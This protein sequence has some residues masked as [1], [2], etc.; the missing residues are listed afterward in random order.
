MQ[1]LSHTEADRLAAMVGAGEPLSAPTRAALAQ[2][3]SVCAACASRE[4]RLAGLVEALQA[5]PEGASQVGDRELIAKAMIQAGTGRPL[6]Q[7]SRPGRTAAILAVAASVAL[8]VVNGLTEYGSRT[9]RAEH[10]PPAN[11]PPSSAEAE[12]DK[13]DVLAAAPAT[14]S[15][16]TPPPAAEP[17]SRL[18][19]PGVRLSWS[20]EPA[21]Q[22][23]A[24]DGRV[25]RLSLQAGV[26][27][28]V[29]D[30]KAH[31]RV[32][33]DT[34]SA[35]VRV[36]GTIFQVAVGD[37]DTSVAVYRGQV[38]VET[39]A[40]GLQ[41]QAG[42]AATS[43]DGVLVRGRAQPEALSTL[44]TLAGGDSPPARAATVAAQRS[45]PT[46]AAEAKRARRSDRGV[47]DLRKL[48]SAGDTRA[49]RARATSRSRAEDTPGRRAELLTIIAESYVIEG[50][51][52]RA[53][54]SY[55]RVWGGARSATAANALI[56]AANVSLERM[57]G[58]HE[59]LALYERYIREYPRGPLRQVAATGRCR[60]LQA[61][62]QHQ[63]AAACANAYLAVHRNSPLR[64]RMQALIDGPTATEGEEH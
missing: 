62:G 46:E 36:L 48:L 29:V 16:T 59:A 12:R 41:L 22:V 52:E 38:A 23:Q 50:Q 1:T 31:M 28:V 54:E 37:A 51:Y 5:A 19:C 44:A 10:P 25:C 57:R 58:A 7:G 20:T 56:A 32:S 40:G 55:S 43:R 30:P 45:R 8:A 61:A 63:R 21:L 53:L 15:V 13:Q 6:R 11:R 4:A 34:P 14:A 42:Q 35:T 18:P 26:A 39:R 3:L 60:A 64:H 17:P 49:A 2:H 9:E 33:I 27:Q 24:S 47:E